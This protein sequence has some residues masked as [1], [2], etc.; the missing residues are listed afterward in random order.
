M[1]CWCLFGY[2]HVCKYRPHT[3]FDCYLVYTHIGCLSIAIWSYRIF[4]RL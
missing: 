2:L 3:Y 4:Y 1:L